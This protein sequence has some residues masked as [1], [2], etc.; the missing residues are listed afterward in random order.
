MENLTYDSSFKEAFGYWVNNLFERISRLFK[1]TGTGDD[2]SGGI[3]QVHIEKPLLINGNVG[4]CKYDGILTA[5]NGS[6]SGVSVYYD[7][8]PFY[9]VRSP[10][11]SDMKT[12]G[13]D[14]TVIRNNST[15]SSLLPM[16]K[17]YAVMLAHAEITLN[18][19]LVNARVS[20]VPTV[21]NTKQKALVDEWRNGLYN[22]KI[23]T[24]LDSGFLSVKWVDINNNAPVN[25]KDLV[26]VRENILCSF[27]HDV[28]VRTTIQKK[29]NLID[30]E[31]KGNDAMLLIN[32]NDMLEER[33][34]GCERVNAM[35]GTNWSVDKCEELK[36]NDSISVDEKGDNSDAEV[37]D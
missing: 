18:T 1:Y 33:Q 7:R 32:I 34:R 36:Y 3:D 30:A 35:F 2:L 21:L 10:L 25:I 28:G 24:L 17:R 26:E 16:V 13:K 22:G 4:I 37:L 23:N 27:Y 9:M 19:L 12:I 5:F 8:Y 20:S 15:E 29:G 6:Y 11:Y 31:L 14:I